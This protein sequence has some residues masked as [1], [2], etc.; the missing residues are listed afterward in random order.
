MSAINLM[1]NSES[2]AVRDPQS[3]ANAR[4]GLIRHDE[5]DGTKA[6]LRNLADSV[7]RLEQRVSELVDEFSDRFRSIDSARAPGFTG[8]KS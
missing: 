3:A 5:S 1:C 6:T 7:Y 8:T 2:D 4:V